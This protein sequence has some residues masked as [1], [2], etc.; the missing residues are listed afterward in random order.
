MPPVSFLLSLSLPFS[1]FS[2]F[3]PSLSLCPRQ[4]QKGYSELDA[5]GL[6]TLPDPGKA[7]GDLIPIEGR[8]SP[9]SSARGPL[10]PGA[11]L[12]VPVVSEG[13]RRSPSL[14]ESASQGQ[15]EGRLGPPL[16]TPGPT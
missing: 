2:L 14:F 10:M 3:S 1:V 5:P 9:H 8:D 6:Q 4:R 15:A 16:L 11:S 13:R 7:S 12:P